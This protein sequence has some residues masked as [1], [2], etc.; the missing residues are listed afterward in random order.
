MEGGNNSGTDDA[1]GAV[2]PWDTTVPERL[3][4]T[5]RSRNNSA[6][7]SCSSSS[8]ISVAIVEVSERLRRS[9]GLPQQSTLDGERRVPA[10]VR[11][12]SAFEPRRGPPSVP[13]LRDEFPHCSFDSSTVTSFPRDND[14]NDSENIDEAQIKNLKKAPSL[15]KSLSVS[16]AAPIVAP[17]I[18]VSSA[19]DDVTTEQNETSEKVGANDTSCSSLVEEAQTKEETS[20]SQSTIGI[21]SSQSLTPSPITPSAPFSVS[22]TTTVQPPIIELSE[23]SEIVE[24]NVEENPMSPKLIECETSTVTNIA[25]LA[26]SEDATEEDESDMNTTILSLNTVLAPVEID[27]AT[28]IKQPLK[29]DE[30]GNEI[31]PWEDE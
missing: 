20:D 3:E 10:P 17:V 30:K 14:N 6:I 27:N 24:E 11:R 1:A 19:I 31:C 4:P 25:P 28:N 23:Q 16:S 29:K 7:D 18:S 13:D 21:L 9:C 12:L 15:L 22:N 2:C 26:E 5:P 8:D